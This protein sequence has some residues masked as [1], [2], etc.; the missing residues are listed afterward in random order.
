VEDVYPAEPGHDSVNGS[1]GS[2]TKGG[3]PDAST[4]EENEEDFV[5]VRAMSDA[6][7][8]ATY[9]PLMRVVQRQLFEDQSARA[10]FL[11][12]NVVVALRRRPKSASANSMLSTE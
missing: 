1:V 3:L 2:H 5:S 9:H 8:P 12:L 6:L 4:A 7:P 10:S 11:R